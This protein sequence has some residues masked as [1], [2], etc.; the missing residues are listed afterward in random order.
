MSL[1]TFYGF[2]QRVFRSKRVNFIFQ[3]KQNRANGSRNHS[4]IT[5]VESEEQKWWIP[6]V[7]KKP[8]DKVLSWRAETFQFLRVKKNEKKWQTENDQQ[9]LP[10]RKKNP[11]TALFFSHVVKPDVRLWC[12]ASH[13]HIL[14]GGTYVYLGYGCR[15]AR[16]VGLAAKLWWNGSRLR[17]LA[18]GCLGFLLLPEC[19][20]GHKVLGGDG[21]VAR[22][23]L[24]KGRFLGR[25]WLWYPCDL[26]TWQ[27][28]KSTEGRLNCV[29]FS[30][31]MI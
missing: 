3:A 14:Q 29:F 15:S 2:K 25:V 18:L 4:C 30:P 17:L 26:L 31:R 11:P 10:D 21:T 5:L 13:Q 19:V 16:C 7:G 9:T 6:Q 23:R 12:V 24:E 20:C 22:R 8:R 1:W 28:Q 27:Q